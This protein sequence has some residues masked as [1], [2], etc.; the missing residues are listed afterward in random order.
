MAPC[1]A[2]AAL[3][4]SMAIDFMNKQLSARAQFNSFS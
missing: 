3:R 4:S 1:E 2:A